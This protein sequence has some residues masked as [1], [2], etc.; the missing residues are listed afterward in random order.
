MAIDNKLIKKKRMMGYFIEA[1]SNIIENEGLEAVTVRK[2]ASLAGYNSA[3][4]YNYFENLH[5]LV[6][7]ASVKYLKEYV[8]C[9]SSNI[10]F[11]KTPIDKYLCIWKCFCEFSYD[12]AQ[13]YHML[14]FN[15]FS[16]SFV[17]VI[18]EYYQIFPEELGEHPE[19][20][21][22]VLLKQNIYERNSTCL[23]AYVKNSDIL[24]E[25]LESINEMILLVYQ[26]MLY[27]IMNNQVNYTNEEAVKITMNYIKK[28]LLSYG[29]I[30]Q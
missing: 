9:I 7:F 26:S 1:A 23:K 14:F 5:H 15:Q 17:D 11:A 28:T 21:L 29:L 22:E 16:D 4:L 30:G 13:I 10:K 8:D 12:K 19:E 27:R 6:Y 3:T 24:Y 20:V 25:S 2:V 18:Q